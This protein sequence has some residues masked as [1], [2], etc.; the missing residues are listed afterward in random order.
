MILRTL[1]LLLALSS[2]ASD[3]RPYGL[4][5]LGITRPDATF[6]LAGSTSG[7][8][9]R[10]DDVEPA[11]KF[12][13]TFGA[14]IRREVAP[15][16]DLDASAALS[17][18]TIGFEANADVGG[19]YS[20]YTINAKE[21]LEFEFEA[22]FLDVE[23][24]ALYKLSPALAIGG[25]AVV[26]IPLGGDMSASAEIT[27]GTM[28]SSSGVCQDMS[29]SGG[30]SGDSEPIEDDQT[31]V[32]LKAQ[33]EYAV[34]ESIGLQALFLYPVGNYVESS[35][36]EDSDVAGKIELAVMRTLVGLTLRF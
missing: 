6:E 30:N 10:V 26:S 3:I 5:R 20:G 31:F 27:S 9:M 21:K 33:G 1:P 29:S 16:L 35:A 32:S 11:S 18:A 4:I 19:T 28:C 2:F 7:I 12:I 17:F 15:N 34:N 24:G 13:G 22:K 8:D 14:G 25:G 23:A 36:D